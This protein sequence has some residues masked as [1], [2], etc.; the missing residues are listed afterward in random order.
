MIGGGLYGSVKAFNQAPDIVE[1]DLRIRPHVVDDRV[2]QPKRAGFHA[3]SRDFHG[4]DFFER[5]TQ[6]GRQ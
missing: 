3:T 1:W 5:A 4:S 6:L 2:A